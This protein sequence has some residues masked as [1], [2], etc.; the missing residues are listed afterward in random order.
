M[1]ARLTDADR[2]TIARARELA[3]L[4]DTTAVQ[5]AAGTA[6]D[7]MT[8]IAMAYARVLGRAQDMLAELAAIAER[9]GGASDAG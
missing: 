5:A 6:G 2:R 9:L 3:A 8:G 7:D 1:T 4:K